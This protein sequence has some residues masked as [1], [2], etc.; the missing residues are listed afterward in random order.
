[1]P[2][3]LLMYTSGQNAGQIVKRKWR[4]MNGAKNFETCMIERLNRLESVFRHFAGRHQFLGHEWRE[5]RT[6]C[7]IIRNCEEDST[8]ST[9]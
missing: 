9:L 4:S 5:I 7:H 3:I 2:M 1:M 6:H 8:D